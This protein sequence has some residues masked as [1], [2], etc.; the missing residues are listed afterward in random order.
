MG[1]SFQKTAK[2]N[3][4]SLAMLRNFHV[5]AII[6]EAPAWQERF[7]RSITD[8]VLQIVLKNED[9]SKKIA[10]ALCTVCTSSF[11]PNWFT[12]SDDQQK[13]ERCSAIK[14]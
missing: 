13:A 7:I 4:T 9:E 14:T 1:S 3:L 8:G 5:N 10:G 11:A 2:S 6:G 12:A